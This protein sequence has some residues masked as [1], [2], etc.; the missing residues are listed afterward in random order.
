[1]PKMAIIVAHLAHGLDALSP[2]LGKGTVVGVRP[3]SFL[4]FAAYQTHVNYSRAK[5]NRQTYGIRR[6]PCAKDQV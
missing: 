6:E 4:A 1:M 2:G 3:A 5:A